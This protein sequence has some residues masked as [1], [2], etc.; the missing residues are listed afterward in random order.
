[1]GVSGG[2]QEFGRVSGGIGA[3]VGETK[4]CRV[5]QSDEALRRR[6]NN[7]SRH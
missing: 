7:P 1:M 3:C 5:K 4:P 6:T 2:E